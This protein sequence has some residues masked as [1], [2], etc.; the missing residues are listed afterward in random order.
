MLQ[1][2]GRCYP[3]AAQPHADGHPTR[4][5]VD[6]RSLAIECPRIYQVWSAA[7]NLIGCGFARKST[8]RGVLTR[9]AFASHLPPRANVTFAVGQHEAE[10][11]RR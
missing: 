3:Q 7:T 4:F 8:E 6:P 2:L 1:S 5:V 10:Y 9:N 11:A